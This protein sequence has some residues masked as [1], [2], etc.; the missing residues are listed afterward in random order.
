MV[1]QVTQF[2]KSVI[3]RLI[4]LNVGQCIR[5]VRFELRIT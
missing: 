1:N 3:L 5:L 4:V 2:G